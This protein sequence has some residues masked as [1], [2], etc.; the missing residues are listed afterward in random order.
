MNVTVVLHRPQDII[1]IAVV[2][3]AMKNFGFRDLSLVS[4]AEFDVRR[5]EGIAHKTGDIVQRVK[6]F[7]ELDEALGDFTL[8]VG[9]TARG[10][11][12]KRNVQFVEDAARDLAELDDSEKVAVLF[13]REDKGLTNEDLDR[14]HRIVTIPTTPEH[15]SM[16]VAQAATVTLYELFKARETLPD[17]KRPR[18]DAPP[19]TR[20]QLEFLFRDAET[21]LDAIEFFKSR[22]E[23]A[24]MR[25]IREIAHRGPIDER[26]TKLLRAMALE[27]VH[28]LE[29][30][31]IRS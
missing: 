30:M 6:M 12:A 7:D 16:N 26:E 21:A 28:Y 1:N 24:I 3:R 19:A 14:C 17:L 4:P 2:I 25:T 11:T 23:E 27:V 10:R 31:D 18:R 8:V 22:N 29:R 20:E 9:L 13:G 15:T 5:V